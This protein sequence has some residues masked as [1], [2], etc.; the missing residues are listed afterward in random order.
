[1][2]DNSILFHERPK[3]YLPSVGEIELLHTEL[4]DERSISAT[5][6]GTLLIAN[7]LGSTGEIQ[8]S[9]SRGFKHPETGLEMI[10]KEIFCLE[11]ETEPPRLL[12]RDYTVAIDEPQALGETNEIRASNRR[13]I[14]SITDM[15]QNFTGNSFDTVLDF[16]E[17]HLRQSSGRKL[18]R[19]EDYLSKILDHLESEI[20]RER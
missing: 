19:A 8:V 11:H 5:H 16:S 6:T 13:I 3:K 12:L 20:E 17:N 18:E 15:P 2:T 9:L 7:D 1:M 4:P 10:R 14:Y